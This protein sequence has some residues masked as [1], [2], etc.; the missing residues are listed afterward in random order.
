MKMASEAAPQSKRQRGPKPLPQEEKGI[1]V[2]TWL[3]NR[4][5]SILEQMAEAQERSLSWLVAKAV[6]E[7]LQRHAAQ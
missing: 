6:K 3:T 5:R 4:D 7:F 2:A 1:V